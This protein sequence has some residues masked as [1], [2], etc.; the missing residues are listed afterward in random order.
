MDAREEKGLVIA[1][2]SKIE[3]NMLG[4]KVPSQSGNGSYI[5]NLDH[6]TPF[7]TCPDYEKRHQPCKHIHAVE[8]VIQRETKPDGTET[9]TKSMKV[10][11]TQEWPAYDNAQMHEQERFVELLRDLCNGIE[12]PTQTFG[13]PRLPLADVV[14]G[15]TYKVYSTMSGRRFMTDLKEAETRELVTKSPSFASS[16]RYLENPELTPLLKTLIEQTASPLK[17]VETDFAVDSSGFATTTYNRWFDHKWGKV[18]SEAKWIKTHL[19]CGVKTHVV[20]SVEVTP[21]ETADVPQLPALVSTTAQTFNISEV[22]ADKAYSS[23]KNLHA[24]QAVNA[25]PYIPFK[26]RTNGVG[27]KSDGFDGLWNRM[28]HFYNFNREQF[29]THYHKRSNVE[30]AFSMIKGKFGASVRSKSPIAQ[31]NEVLCKIL[32]HNICV[33]ISSIYELGLE[34]TFWTSDTEEAVV[35]KVLSNVV[36]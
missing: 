4:W 29:L 31:V 13:R 8:F 24:V 9:V 6:G 7:C 27:S 23:R 12:Q 16:A 33:L 10:T 26:N 28:W 25:T 32:C 11:C 20:T 36:F 17:A 1:A 22:S 19:M 18:R 35:P 2:T 34:P 21:T 3:K 30:T 5:V 14:F 15:V